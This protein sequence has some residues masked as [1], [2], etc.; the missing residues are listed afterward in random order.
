M[1]ENYIEEV[2]KI[3]IPSFMAESLSSIISHKI[4]EDFDF[5]SHDSKNTNIHKSIAA[6]KNHIQHE[7]DH[8]ISPVAPVSEIPS[9]VLPRGSVIWPSNLSLRE[10]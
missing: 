2:L 1:S 4:A 9:S 6:H 3:L 10:N 7:T 8:Q 5:S